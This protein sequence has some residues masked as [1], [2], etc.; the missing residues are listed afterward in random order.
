MK[1]NIKF[2]LYTENFEHWCIWDSE[3]ERKE[4]RARL[5]LKEQNPIIYERLYGDKEK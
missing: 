5:K 4:E 1:E 3:Q 2:I